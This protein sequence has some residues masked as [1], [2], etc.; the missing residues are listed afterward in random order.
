MPSRARGSAEC[1]RRNDESAH[2]GACASPVQLE[3]AAEEAPA[4][5]ARDWCVLLG[6]SAVLV[7][8]AGWL[9]WTALVWVPRLLEQ[10]NK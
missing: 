8:S 9:C 3:L 4:A 6:W 10:A 5:T 2:D 1:R 7:W